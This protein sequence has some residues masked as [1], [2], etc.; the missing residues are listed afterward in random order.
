MSAT[1]LHDAGCAVHPADR[2]R[3][4][5]RDGMISVH[6]WH[7]FNFAWRADTEAEGRAAIM[8][9]LLRPREEAPSR[10]RTNGGSL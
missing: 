7:N 2:Y 9:Y 8:A 10:Q 3:I 1:S 5:W 4:A 6:R